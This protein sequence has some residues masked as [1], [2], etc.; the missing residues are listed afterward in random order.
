MGPLSGIRIVEFAGI[1]P[2]P[3]CAMML[4]DMGAGIIRLERSG[5]TDPRGKFNVLHRGRPAIGIDLKTHDGVTRA[6]EL[7]EHADALIEGFRPGVMEKLGL[8]PDVCLARNPRLVYGRMTGWGQTGPLAHAAG[9]DINY[10]SLSGAL[11]AIGPLDGKPVPPL[12]LVGDFGGGGM[13]LAFGIVCALLEA[14]KS[15][16]GQVV[17]AA[18]TDGSASLMAIIYG[19]RAMGAWTNDRG[20]NMLDGGAHFYDTYE[21]AD[22]RYVSIGSIEPQ[23]YALLLEKSGLD[24][25]AP[26][27]YMDKQRWPELKE[28]LAAAIK[29]KT[30]DEWCALMEGTDICFAPVLDLDEAPVHPHNVARGT[31]VTIDGVTQPAPAPRFSRTAPEIQMNAGQALEVMRAWGLGEKQLAAWQ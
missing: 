29:T 6:L 18:M 8:G 26:R 12:N 20:A 31:F 22:G 1:G 28:R 23:F 21:C 24:D 10:I 15:G 14:A 9:H 2:G 3:Y 27:S 30:R 5:V 4:A 17:D 25:P 13:M 7:L 11:H 19:L 16:K